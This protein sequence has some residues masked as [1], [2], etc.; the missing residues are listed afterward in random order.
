MLEYALHKRGNTMEFLTTY[1][2]FL[3]EVVTITLA[4]ILILLAIFTLS[5]RKDSSKD[6]KIKIT[7]LNE[8]YDGIQDDINAEI[9]NKAALKQLKQQRKQQ[10]KAKKKTELP[11]L[12][13]V[14]FKGDI[15]ASAVEALREE[16][17][18]ILLSANPQDEVLVCIESS[19]GMVNAYGLAA[20]QLQRIKSAGIK[21]T[22]AIDKVAASGGYMM[23]CVADHIIAAPFAVVG[24]IGVI[25]QVPNFHR[26]LEKRNI[27]FEQLTA[28]EYKRTLSLFGENTRKGRAKL[29]EEIED[30]HILFKDFIQTFRNTIDMDKVATGEHWFAKRAIDFNL[31]DALQTSDDFLLQNKPQYQLIE[32]RHQQ[33]LPLGKR[34]LGG[35]AN[36]LLKLFHE[37][38]SLGGRDY[39]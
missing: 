18:A 11:H 5:S 22:V 31:V 10:A 14:R 38:A 19:G 30:T 21:L 37:P 2:L 3:A 6:G 7:K 4:I 28:G 35:G 27:E 9:L 15:K 16:V 29:Q 12:F 39:L 8:R 36:A 13:V 25:A 1:G 32:I 24:S 23:A 33:K 34:L 20:S 26:F 17:T